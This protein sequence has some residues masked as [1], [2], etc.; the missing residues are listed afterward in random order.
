MNFSPDLDG[1]AAS[2]GV[3]WDGVL[4]LK[5]VNPVNTSVLLVDDDP[6]QLRYLSYLVSRA[7]YRVTA[8]TTVHDALSLLS[9]R[10]F[11]ILISDLKMP[12]MN[13]FE[14]LKAVRALERPDAS[15]PI[16]VIVLTGTQGD[17]EL[18]AIEQ[19]ADMFCEKFRVQT[20]LPKQIQF[21]LEE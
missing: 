12:E 19:G 8:T 1:E 16:P 7:G 4:Q 21:L 6:D 20:L 18:A 17:V 3:D 5:S 9:E 13:G 2:N 14:F 15:R 10:Q 11:Q